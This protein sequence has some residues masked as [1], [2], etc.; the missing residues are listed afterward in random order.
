MAHGSSSGIGSERDCTGRDVE[1]RGLGVI[2]CGATMGMNSFWMEMSETY[3]VM[4]TMMMSPYWT[5]HWCFAYSMH[6]IA[7]ENGTWALEG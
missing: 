2:F 3:Q 7:A 5:D 4:M 1:E 6:T